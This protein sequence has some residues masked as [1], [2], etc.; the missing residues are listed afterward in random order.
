MRFAARFPAYG[1]LLLTVLLWSGNWIVGRAVR[2]DMSPALATLGRV[3]IVMVSVAPFALSGLRERLRGLSAEE[4]RIVLIAGLAGGGPH[5]AMQWLAL[6]Y[7][8]ATSAT[9]MVS[10]APIFILL[11][12]SAFL[13]ER[14]AGL[15]WIGVAV[16]FTGIAVIASSGDLS[17]LATLALNRGDLLAVGSMFFFAAYTV[18]LKRRRDALSTMQF[19]LVISCVGAIALTPWVAWELA[20]DA[21]ATLSRNGIFAFLY[22]GIGSFLLAY[23]GW[24]YAVPRL[25]AGRAG[26]WMHLMP[27]FAVVLAAIFLAE[28]PHW[29]HFAG[30][31][32]IIAGVRAS[33]A[34]STR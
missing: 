25:G 12:A 11:L 15:Q 17:A 1:A 4:W 29:F 19:L 14:I 8:T 18:A 9:L 32:L 2:N 10:T 6:H 22:S 34:S 28:Y 3:A 5:L 24:S 16:S 7:T 31:A 23:L 30:I 20:H 26:A 33:S 27:A 21:R 13:G